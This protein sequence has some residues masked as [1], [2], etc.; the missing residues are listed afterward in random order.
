[1]GTIDKFIGGFFLAIVIYLILDSKSK[2]SDV[3]GA[4][5]GG[6][7]KLAKALQGRD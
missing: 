7:S 5:A 4:S 6:F 1:M 2:T 3:I